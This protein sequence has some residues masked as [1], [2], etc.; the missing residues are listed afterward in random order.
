MEKDNYEIDCLG[1]LEADREYAISRLKTVYA[2]SIRVI[3]AADRI[4]IS[5]V[6]RRKPDIDSWVKDYTTPWLF[7]QNLERS[8]F[9]FVNLYGLKNAVYY[10]DAYELRIDVTGGTPDYKEVHY[11]EAAWFEVTTHYRSLRKEGRDKVRGVGFSDHIK[12]SWSMRRRA[13]D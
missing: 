10:D 11:L 9:E 6:K 3:E 12:Y 4:D 13:N 8:V 2:D 7:W 1:M 5:I